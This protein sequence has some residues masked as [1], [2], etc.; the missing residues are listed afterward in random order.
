MFSIFFIWLTFSLVA[1]F[2]CCGHRWQYV[3]CSSFHKGLI[4]GYMFW[5]SFCRCFYHVNVYFPSASSKLNTI[6][7][8]S[9]AWLI[10]LSKFSLLQL[11]FPVFRPNESFVHNMLLFICWLVDYTSDWIAVAKIAKHV[12]QYKI[13]G[14]NM[15]SW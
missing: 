7:A 9:Y 14:H 11:Y 1:L 15:I 12:L 4:V 5:H 13:S 8:Y 10:I 2:L 3:E 6:G